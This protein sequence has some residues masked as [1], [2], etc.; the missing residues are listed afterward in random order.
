MLAV[1][2]SHPPYRDTIPSLE[3]LPRWGSSWSHGWFLLPTTAPQRCGAGA[4]EVAVSR[5]AAG[6]LP[7]PLTLP[8]PLPLDNRK[9]PM[10]RHVSLVC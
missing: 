9:G 10:T 3:F 6:R 5:C 2:G 7:L 1:K 4:S 8:E